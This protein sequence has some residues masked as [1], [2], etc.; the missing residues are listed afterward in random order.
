RPGHYR[1]VKLDP[2]LVPVRDREVLL[3]ALAASPAKRYPSCLGLIEALEEAGAE[4]PPADDL[5]DT[6]PAGGP[7]ASPLR[8]PSSP[9]AVLPRAAQLVKA[10]T[11]PPEARLVEAAPNVRYS[12][13]PDG[14]RVYRCPVELTFPGALALKVEGLRAH[15]H[16]RLTAR[17][18][19][20]YRLVIDLA[21]PPRQG[22]RGTEE[23]RRPGVAVQAAP[24]RA[25]RPRTA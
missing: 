9:D 16:A 12:I 24:P 19:N 13:L 6:L 4:R 3:R 22:E 2:S 18:G 15:W 7:H 17:G 1:T 5:Y 14:S 21:A 10:L 23:A 20:A 25:A 8:G 11:A